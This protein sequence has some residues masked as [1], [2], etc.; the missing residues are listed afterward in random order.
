MII[1]QRIA[2]FNVKND[3][4]T[5]TEV[6]L[7]SSVL[8]NIHSNTPFLLSFIFKPNQKA[9]HYIYYTICIQYSIP[10]RYITMQYRVQY[11]QQW[12]QWWWW[13]ASWDHSMDFRSM[14][15]C[16]ISHSS[17]GLSGGGGGRP[18]TTRWTSDQCPPAPSPTEATYPS[19][20]IVVVA[21][22]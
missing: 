13:W 6:S 10:V 18:G 3:I 7:I 15:S 9:I 8:S 11:K 4:T 1:I 14:P 16:T 19:I 12:A 20:C 5:S 21:V 2:F 22:R 17:P